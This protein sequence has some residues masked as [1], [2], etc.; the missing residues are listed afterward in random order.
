MTLASGRQEEERSTIA[1]SNLDIMYR[2]GGYN[3][4]V[5]TVCPSTIVG[6]FTTKVLQRTKCRHRHPPIR[7]VHLNASQDLIA[8][9]LTAIITSRYKEVTSNL[10][11]IPQ[12]YNPEGNQH[13]MHPL[14]FDRISEYK[15]SLML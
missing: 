6:T 2:I 7:S 9:T 5:N 3:R 1:T 11:Q 8:I 15:K 10:N 14:A 13:R 4:S 12:V